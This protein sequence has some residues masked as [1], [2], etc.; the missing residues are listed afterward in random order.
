VCEE[1]GNWADRA[2]RRRYV[3]LDCGHTLSEGLV[4]RDLI[5]DRTGSMVSA[6]KAQ[7]GAHM[8]TLNC[9]T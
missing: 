3:G 5:P 2:S 1:R 8:L 6:A 7:C 4:Y 9:L